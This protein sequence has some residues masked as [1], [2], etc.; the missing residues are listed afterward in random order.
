MNEKEKEAVD[1]AKKYINILLIHDIKEDRYY[2]IHNLKILLNLIEKQ[3]KEIEDYKRVLI[4]MVN[5]FAYDEKRA[6]VENELLYTGGIS[7]LE[8]AF[9][10]LDIDE[11]IKRKELWNMLKEIKNE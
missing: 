3:Q 9:S 11:G 2:D 7:A 4:D 5:Q 6:K 1:M 10:V 8:E